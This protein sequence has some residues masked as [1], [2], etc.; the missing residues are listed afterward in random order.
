MNLLSCAGPLLSFKDATDLLVS[1]KDVKSLAAL[2]EIGAWKLRPRC[3]DIGHLY[4]DLSNR[5]ADEFQEMF[6]EDMD[7]DGQ[8]YIIT[9]L[10]TSHF[11]KLLV[12]ESQDVLLIL[13]TPPYI[14]VALAFIEDI[15]S[16]TR[17]GQFCIYLQAMVARYAFHPVHGEAMF[18]LINELKMVKFP[19]AKAT[20]LVECLQWNAVVAALMGRHDFCMLLKDDF[21]LILNDPDY[22]RQI[23]IPL[24]K[25]LQRYAQQKVVNHADLLNAAGNLLSIRSSEKCPEGI[26][27]ERLYEIFREFIGND[28]N[29]A[30][31]KA[32][33]HRYMISFPL[34]Q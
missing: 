32:S 2:A 14:I 4:H 8:G 7:G 6:S 25:Q 26:D 5:T 22:S 27:I 17:L 3:P 1:A 21:D 24:I 28:Q 10:M 34:N 11:K 9:R 16:P 31:M 18:N 15:V 33:L 12:D 19:K 29:D 13:K 20:V 23:Y 30:V